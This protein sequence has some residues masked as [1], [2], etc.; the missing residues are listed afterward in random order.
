MSDDNK[1]L[2]RL[3]LRFA[4]EIAWS[5]FN[6]ARGDLGDHGLFC[7]DEAAGDVVSHVEHDLDR[8]HADDEI[9]DVLLKLIESLNT[10]ED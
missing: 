3:L 1:D 10:W 9:E 7:V 6:K 5:V 4:S 2:R 8:I